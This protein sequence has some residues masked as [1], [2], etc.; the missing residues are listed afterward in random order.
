[1]SEPIF[2]E[3]SPVASNPI[4]YSFKMGEGFKLVGALAV[5]SPPVGSAS[6]CEPSVPSEMGSWHRL[7]PPNQIDSVYIRARWNPDRK[8]WAPALEVQGRRV[9]F[10]SAYLAAIGWTY[11]EAD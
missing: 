11:L 7:K 4:A 9:A 5:P 8:Y 3:G 1:M 2:P 10:S 6:D